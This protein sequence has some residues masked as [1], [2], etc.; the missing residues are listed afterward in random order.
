MV[1]YPYCLHVFERDTYFCF[2]L[3]LFEK[4]RDFLNFVAVTV[5]DI[6]QLA[7]L[8]RPSIEGRRGI[9]VSSYNIRELNSK[10]K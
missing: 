6:Y 10:A 2:C 5:E 8:H 1:D 4:L 9:F 3:D 7:N